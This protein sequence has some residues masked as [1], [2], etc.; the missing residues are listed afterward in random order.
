[1]TVDPVTAAVQKLYDTYPFPPEPLSDQPPPGYNWR[2]SWPAAYDFCTGRAPQTQAIKIL[3]A[4]C[5]TGVSTEYLAHLNPEAEITAID[6]SQGA[7]AVAQ[8]RIRRLG[9]KNVTFQQASLLDDH[10][11]LPGPFDLI[12]SVGVLHHLRDPERG[13]AN[14]AKHL[15]PGGIFHIFVYGELGRWEISLMQEAIGLLQ[16][17]QRGNYT[18]GV[19]LGREIFAVLP[20]NNRLKQRE[21]E[22]WAMENLRDECFADM[23]LHPQ[24]VTY[25]IPSLFAWIETTDL[26]FLGFSNPGMWQLERL[27]GNNPELME[28]A[29]QLSAQEQYHLIELLD[30]SS[31]THFEFFLGRPPLPRHTWTNAEDLLEAIPRLHPCLDGWPGQ[32]LFNSFYEVIHLTEAETGFLQACEQNPDQSVAQ[33]LQAAPLSPKAVY[34]LWQRKLILLRPES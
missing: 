20:E 25:T 5:G 16:G 18:D 14:L 32:C 26:E 8:E 31:V 13:L 4:G 19:R 11:T 28:R 34:S 17:E 21:T 3:D 2:W 29:Q 23:Y 24:E 30:P 12:N 1:M 9:A 6:I 33:L 10:L 15:K 22:R 7:L 27:L